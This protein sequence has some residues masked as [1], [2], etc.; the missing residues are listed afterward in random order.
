MAQA[1]YRKWRPKDWDQVIG[2]DHVIR[3]LRNAFARGNFTHAY[4]FSG[5]RGTGKTTTARIIAK[6]LNC[7][8]EDQSARPCNQ[9][10]HCV[11]I[12]QSRFLDL[13]EI[14][15]ASNTSVDDV[16]D[17][18]EKIN[19]SPT[20]GRYK[21]YIIDE[22]HMLSNAAF[23]ALLKT[24]EEPPAHAVFILATTEVQKIPPTVLSRCQRHEFRRIPL[25]YIQ[26]QL[27]EIAKKENIDVEPAA[28]I[29]IARQATG[30][31][32]DAV[33]L[34]DQLASTG[35]TVDLELTK[36]VLGTAGG[37]NVY[38][39]VTAILE[40][41]AG[42]AIS[43]INHALDHGSDPRQFGR[44]V[45]DVFRSV[46]M[47]KMGNFDQIEMTQD[48]TE[49]IKDFA[50]AFPMGKLLE[51][52]RAFDRAA[53]RTNA[54]WQPGLQLE[55]AAAKIANPI[56]NQ[57]GADPGES[58]SKRVENGHKRNQTTNKNRAMKDGPGMADSN[59]VE[60]NLADSR[61]N[62]VTK[63]ERA[64][65]ESGEAHTFND[66]NINTAGGKDTGSGSVGIDRIKSSWKNIR[67][68]AK[69]KSPE[70]AALLNSSR[71]MNIR[72][73][74][75]VLGFASEILRSKMENGRNIE[76]AREAIRDVCGIEV[77]ID[78][79]V[80]GNEPPPL[81]DGMEI[82]RDGMVGEALS[83]GGKITKKEKATDE[84]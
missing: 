53:Q 73:G 4:L 11:E 59:A 60:Q 82:E 75:L 57:E 31:M 64:E 5:P 68:A 72:R 37:E 25:N 6:A 51:A 55:L 49:K 13:I 30:S 63:P 18:R 42:E 10:E 81:P 52:L 40:N 3:T 61:N 71:S 77:E 39:L 65:N 44:Q 22:V 48:E 66:K 69:K 38:K 2:Q 16:R 80:A 24:L 27:K 45:A 84:D 33:S 29:A 41:N 70:T 50:S 47:A 17:L 54:G 19:F 76:L 83:L 35:L 36:Q 78:C 58:S 79:I 43:Q 67:T 9:C 62:S 7:L 46:L 56:S 12:N 1:Y 32:R 74:R 21:V 26:M 34:L 8:S 23:N 14:D 28:L 15:A 20:K